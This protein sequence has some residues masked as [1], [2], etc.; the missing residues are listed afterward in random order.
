MPN[1]ALIQAFLDARL[2]DARIRTELH[3]DPMRHEYIIRMSTVMQGEIRVSQRELMGSREHTLRFVNHGLEAFRRRIEGEDG[4][5]IQDIARMRHEQE[6]ERLRL[7]PGNFAREYLGTFNTAAEPAAQDRAHWWDYIPPSM[8][9]DTFRG[10]DRVV[11][12]RLRGVRIPSSLLKSEKKQQPPK[13][14]SFWEHLD[15]E[16]PDPEPAQPTGEGSGLYWAAVAD[17]WELAA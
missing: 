5:D 4:A 1:R 15:H 10:V 12:E 11:D 17:E 16:W 13:A 14:V 3:Q 9:T 7:P 6:L 8:P 2:P